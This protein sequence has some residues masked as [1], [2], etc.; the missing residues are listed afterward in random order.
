[1]LARPTVAPAPAAAWMLQACEAL[2]HRANR[3][4]VFGS[5]ARGDRRRIEG[6]GGGEEGRR[7]ANRVGE[8]P[9]LHVRYERGIFRMT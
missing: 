2:E 7:A 9:D 4:G 6:R 1:M 8:L 5:V 3:R